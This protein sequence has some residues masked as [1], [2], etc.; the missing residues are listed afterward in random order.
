M[1]TK[2][3][4]N[5]RAVITSPYGYRSNPFD[6]SKQFH[7]G[8]DISLVNGAPNCVPIYATKSGKVAV[9]NYNPGHP[10]GFGK[11]VYIQLPDG[12]YCCYF[13][14]D[15]VCDDFKVGDIIQEGAFI[16]IMGNTGNSLGRH[17][18]YEERPGFNSGGSRNPE[19]ISALYK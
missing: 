6:G 17:L 18:H 9:V 19:D 8:I 14:L 16:G 13:H 5:S 10:G 3:V 4:R 11:C 2:P 1:A 12:W 7:G 15:F